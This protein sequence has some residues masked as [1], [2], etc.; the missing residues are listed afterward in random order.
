MESRTDDTQV[1]HDMLTWGILAA[2]MAL[3]YV[4]TSVADRV[5][6]HGYNDY[7]RELVRYW[8]TATMI[9]PGPYPSLPRAAS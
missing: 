1:A 8:H 3:A 2:C 6:D 5:L 7:R 9:V 4:M